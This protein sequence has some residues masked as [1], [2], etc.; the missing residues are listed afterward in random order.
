[1]AG[2][3]VPVRAVVSLTTVVCVAGVADLKIMVLPARRAAAPSMAL[4]IQPR[5]SVRGVPHSNVTSMCR[6][7]VP[8][9]MHALP[10]LVHDWAD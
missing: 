9:G 4:G 2:E 1:M 3:A 8:A 6:D 5:S 7:A 10:A